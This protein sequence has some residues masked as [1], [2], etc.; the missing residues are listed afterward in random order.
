MSVQLQRDEL[1]RLIREVELS[2]LELYNLELNSAKMANDIELYHA[3]IEKQRVKLEKIDKDLSEKKV[4][5]V[6]QAAKV[7]VLKEEVAKLHSEFSTE[8]ARS[9]AEES[10]LLEIRTLYERRMRVFEALTLDVKE[11]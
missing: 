8:M 11:E 1:A 5:T 3:E 10:E 9:I 2:E 7:K 4:A 6:A